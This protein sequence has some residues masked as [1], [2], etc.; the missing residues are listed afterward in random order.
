MILQIIGV[1]TFVGA[2]YFVGSDTPKLFKNK[3]WAVAA[4]GPLVWYAVL[5]AKIIGELKVK[6]TKPED[7]KREV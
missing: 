7:R 3:W 6:D 2:V 4:H 5:C 1:W